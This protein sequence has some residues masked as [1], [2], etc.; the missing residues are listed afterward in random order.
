M[1]VSSCC[2]HGLHSRNRESP[3][4]SPPTWV[5]SPNRRILASCYSGPTLVSSLSNYSGFLLLCPTH[6]ASNPPCLQMF[7]KRLHACRCLRM[8]SVF[9]VAFH[10]VSS[11]FSNR[12]LVHPAYTLILRVTQQIQVYSSL[13]AWHVQAS[14]SHQGKSPYNP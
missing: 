4:C 13:V 5:W 11:S 14:A 9:C 3:C 6:H 2:A 12:I 7:W 10:S 8:L 1:L